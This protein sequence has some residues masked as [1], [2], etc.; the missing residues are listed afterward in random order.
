MRNELYI[1]S[2]YNPVETE[3]DQLTVTELCRVISLYYNAFK[4][5]KTTGGVAEYHVS[6]Q[7][8]HTGQK[9]QRRPVHLNNPK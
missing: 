2:P 1:M 4:L 9:N 5:L 6:K 3:Q 7:A 8:D